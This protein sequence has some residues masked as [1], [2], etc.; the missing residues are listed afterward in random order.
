MATS[1]IARMEKDRPDNRT[2]RQGHAEIRALKRAITRAATSFTLG[3][4]ALAGLIAGSCPRTFLQR[5][6]RD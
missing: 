2:R 1:H 4:R 3:P 6:A 5:Q